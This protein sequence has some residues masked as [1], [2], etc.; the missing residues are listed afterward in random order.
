MILSRS[1]SCLFRISS[2]SVSP[3]LEGLSSSLWVRSPS[4]RLLC[5]SLSPSLLGR[6]CSSLFPSRRVRFSSSLFPSRRVRVGS[7]LFFLV[8]ATFSFSKD[9]LSNIIFLLTLKW[10]RVDL[11][12]LYSYLYWKHL[13]LHF[14]KLDYILAPSSSSPSSIQTVDCILKNKLTS[15]KRLFVKICIDLYSHSEWFL[16]FKRFKFKRRKI[17]FRKVEDDK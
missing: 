10:T 6:M 13:R 14:I 3:S 1:C 4:R 2:S 11:S 9:S 16:K 5:S 8:L 15:I 12:R 7:S 17:F